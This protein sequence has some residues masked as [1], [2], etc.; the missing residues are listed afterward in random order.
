MVVLDPRPRGHVLLPQTRASGVDGRLTQDMAGPRIAQMA[1]VSGPRQV[2]K[3][4]TC[5]GLS[6]ADLNWDSVEAR[7]GN[8]ELS[9]SLG[10]F[11]TQTQ[12]RH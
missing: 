1:F 4:T 5:R 3:T 2:G 9:N 7:N 10:Y 6:F 11:Q 12:A 8:D